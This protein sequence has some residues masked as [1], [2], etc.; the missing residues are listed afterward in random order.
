MKAT[1]IGPGWF[2]SDPR[3]HQPLPTLL[4]E[5]EEEASL[6]ADKIEARGPYKPNFFPCTIIKEAGG[7]LTWVPR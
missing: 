3:S 6:H 2:V 4:T 7:R 1:I 5:S